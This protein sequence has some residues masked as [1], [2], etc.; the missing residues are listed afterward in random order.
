[1]IL[2]SWGAQ[3]KQS[4]MFDTFVSTD[5]YNFSLFFVYLIASWYIIKYSLSE[6]SGKQYVSFAL[7]Q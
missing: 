7:G 5:A 4:I 1:M 6:T 3:R 2:S